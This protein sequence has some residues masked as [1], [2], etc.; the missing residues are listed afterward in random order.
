MWWRPLVA[1]VLAPL[2][3]LGYLAYVAV[4]TR[5]LDGWFWIEKHTCH[6]V[7][8]WGASTLRVV[9]GTVLGRP[10]VADVLVVAALIAAV[11]LLFWSLTE[12]IPVYL[13]VYTAVIVVMALTTSANWI[14]SKPRFLLP[15][16]LLALPLAPVAGPGPYVG[17]CPADRGPGRRGHL[18]RPLSAGHRRGGRREP[19]LAIAERR[20]EST[21]RRKVRDF[22]AKGHHFR[23]ETP[24]APVKVPASPESYQLFLTADPSGS[25][26]AA[27]QPRARGSG[28]RCRPGHGRACL[29]SGRPPASL[30]SPA[31]IPAGSP[32]G[33]PLAARPGKGRAVCSKSALRSCERYAHQPI[34]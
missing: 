31:D 1:A 29:R 13:H 8:D 17:A 23:R 14:S 16:F 4:A 21:L 26:P 27:K 10:S 2:G 11:F 6:M 28:G 5:R 25:P 15:A 9:D 18:V 20:V 33:E 34:P 19:G 30:Q 32:A 3:L 24:T 7:F 12:R 22:S